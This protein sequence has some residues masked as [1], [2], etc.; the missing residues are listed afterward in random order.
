MSE[1]LPATSGIKVYEP[2]LAQ[3]AE[4]KEK[5]DTA[6]AAIAKGEVAHIKINY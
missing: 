3:L 2:F 5:N 6:V 1:V 4:F